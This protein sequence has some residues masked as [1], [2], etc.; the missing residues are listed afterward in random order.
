[1]CF[2]ATASFGASAAIA[3]VAVASFRRASTAASYAVACIPLAFSIQQAFEGL[4]WLSL[5]HISYKQWQGFAMNGFLVFATVV[6]PILI[7]LIAYL[8]EGKGIR[9]KVMAFFCAAGTSIGLY[10]LWC[11]I[12]Y[13]VT[14]LILGRHI[15]YELHFPGYNKDL[16]TAVYVMATIFPPLFSTA[17]PLRW[18]GA[19]LLV[20][21][22][23]TAYFYKGYLIS[24]WC[25]FA[26]VLSVESYLIIRWMG[27]QERH[28]AGSGNY[29]K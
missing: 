27:H 11:L 19:L 6:W 17:R 5:R 28:S 29:H 25:Y 24:V 22:F 1:M 7:P 8:L 18:F 12:A 4:L 23:F 13:E 14:P 16:M 20:S 21:F 2:S 10:F 15:R 3:L 26:A 9:K